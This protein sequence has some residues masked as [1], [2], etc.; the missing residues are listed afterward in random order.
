MMKNYGKAIMMVNLKNENVF[1]LC[2]IILKNMY[3]SYLL[4]PFKIIQ[5]NNFKK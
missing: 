4:I 1:I 5:K 2:T 3:V